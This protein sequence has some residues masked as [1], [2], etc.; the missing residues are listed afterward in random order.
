[1][2]TIVNGTH[3]K[4]KATKSTSMCLDYSQSPPTTSRFRPGMPGDMD[5]SPEL[6]STLHH[7][8]HMVN[9]DCMIYKSLVIGC[10]TSFVQLLPLPP[11]NSPLK[12]HW[13]LSKL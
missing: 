13:I 1:M 2:L 3:S 12:V 5:P 9:N 4:Q 8:S 7:V 10:H 6:S 11:P